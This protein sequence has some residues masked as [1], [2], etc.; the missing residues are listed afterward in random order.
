[1]NE[2]IFN[3]ANHYPISS[4]NQKPLNADSVSGKDQA[5]LKKVAQEFE[6][7]F[8]AQLLKIMRETIEESGMEGSGGFGKSIYTDLFDQE[9]A[10]SMASRGA[11]GIGDII[12][13]N[14]TGNGAAADQDLASTAQS[15]WK[16]SRPESENLN[17]LSPSDAA[18]SAREISIPF[19]PVNAPV[20]SNFGMRNDPF[21]GKQRFH[22]GIDIA[23]PAGTPVAAALPG[24]VISA[25]YERGYGNTVLVEHDG[26][27]Q[28]RYGHLASINVKAGDTVT[29]ENVIGRVG[30][31]GRS[32]GAHLHFEVIRMGTQVDPA[33]LA[34]FMK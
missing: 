11:L 24:K 31:T 8:I 25:G 9:V 19:L 26:G 1:M 17:T 14:L 30:S 10:L 3:S 20:S 33:R 27:L 13:R 21:T 32:T 16:T 34:S 28:T 7:V 12:Y 2:L 5:D 4:L 22:K 18:D 29:S 23:A 6:A 15:G